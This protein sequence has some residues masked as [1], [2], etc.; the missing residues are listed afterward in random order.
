MSIKEKCEPMRLECTELFKQLLIPV[1]SFPQ[2]RIRVTFSFFLEHFDVL[3]KA[4]C[5]LCPILAHEIHR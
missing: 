2:L 1:Q 4:H 3:D 5:M